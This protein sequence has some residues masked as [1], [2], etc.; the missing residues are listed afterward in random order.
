MFHKKFGLLIL[1]ALYFSMLPQIGQ[2][3]EPPKSITVESIGTGIIYQGDTAKAR[4]RAIE[5]SLVVAVHQ[6]VEEILPQAERL[7]AFEQLNQW[8]FVQASQFIQHYKVI[9]EASRAN[10]YRVL[11]EAKVSPALIEQKL[12]AAGVLRSPHSLPSVLLLMDPA[13][14]AH[15][16]ESTDP[17]SY[18]Q[19]ASDIIA[20]I[21]Q[22]HQYTLIDP[23]LSA[24]Q[25]PPGRLTL[26]KAMAL[27]SRFQADVIVMGKVL[28]EPGPISTNGAVQSIQGQVNLNAYA[29][30]N[31]SALAS[32]SQMEVVPSYNDL[33]GEN[34]AVVDASSLAGR[35]LADKL[36]AAWQSASQMT[37]SYVVS[38]EGA[39]PMIA[40]VRFRQALSTMPNVKSV[41]T[42]EMQLDKST[43]TVKYRGSVQELAQTLDG[44]TF[45][46]YQVKIL[47]IMDSE[48]KVRLLTK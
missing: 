17:Q 24:D 25:I 43:L 7:A 42:L 37:Q 32:V 40:F 5:N 12:K 10:V 48:L 38:V 22:Q 29:T 15:Q 41:Q 4:K 45:D 3:A 28:I 14:A 33:A 23:A 18:A 9:A 30:A 13:S 19:Q 11:V 16:T 21:L 47:V 26:Q 36:A 35:E 46:N 39:S 1:L 6:A 31:G 34:K 20:G 2:A 44:T 27:G 8:I